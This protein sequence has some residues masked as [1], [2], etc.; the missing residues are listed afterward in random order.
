MNKVVVIIV[1]YNGMKWIEECLNSVLNSSIPV[2]I[3]VVDNNS[4]DGTVEYIKEVFSNV[5]LLEQNI[6]LGFGKANNIGMS[7][8]LKNCADFVFLLNQDAFVGKDTIEKLTEVALSNPNYG[9]LSPI[10]LDYSGK[11]LE[12]YFFK[13]MADD[14]SRTFYSDFVLNNELKEIY[15][16]NFIQAAA[17]LLPIKTIMKMG[18]F[19]PI[20]FHYGEDNNFCQRVLYHNLKIGVAPNTFIRHDA[21]KHDVGIVDLFTEKYFKLYKQNLC[22]VYGDLNL[23]FEGSFINKERKKIYFAILYNLIKLKL[24]GAKGYYRK[25]VT[26]EHTMKQIEISRKNNIKINTHYINV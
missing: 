7:Y 16:V 11:L 12:N 18:G 6:N 4:S 14:R 20:F 23:Q 22:V 5:I 3:I 24:K 10:Q 15:D 9:I 26:L 25:L 21:N 2:S 1:T 8:A 13:F 19:D 17:W